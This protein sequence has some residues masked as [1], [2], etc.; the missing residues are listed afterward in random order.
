MTKKRHSSQIYREM[1]DSYQICMLNKNVNF[2]EIILNKFRLLSVSCHL[3][4]SP[5]NGGKHK[6]RMA[7]EVVN[8]IIW[9]PS[10]DNF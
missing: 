8:K 1:K 10:L 2:T 3:Y 5:D 9:L 4:S 7:T 6:Y